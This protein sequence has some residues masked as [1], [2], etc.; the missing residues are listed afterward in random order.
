M[1]PWPVDE[2]DACFIARDKLRVVTYPAVTFW[3]NN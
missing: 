2:G 3:D 1:P